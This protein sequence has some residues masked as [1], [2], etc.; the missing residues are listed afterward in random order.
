M[1][2]A[3]LLAIIFSGVQK[4]PFGYVSGD[5]PLVTLIPA[6]GTTYVA[7]KSLEAGRDVKY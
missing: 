5:E 1:G 6:Q 7:G 3:V 2:V 4:H